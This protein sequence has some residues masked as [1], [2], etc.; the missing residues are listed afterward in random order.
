M[1]LERIFLMMA[2]QR[3]DISAIGAVNLVR[4]FYNL[5]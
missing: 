4:Y 5:F 3:L 2:S 1:L